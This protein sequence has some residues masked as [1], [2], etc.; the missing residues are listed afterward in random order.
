MPVL[1]DPTAIRLDGACTVED[2]LA[3]VEALQSDPPL[4]VALAGCTHLHTAPL[5]VL[6][7]LRP[8]LASRFEEPFLAHWVGPLLDGGAG[9]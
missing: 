2:A 9:G 7:A 4:P 5:Q 8:P 3:L 6:L 1:R